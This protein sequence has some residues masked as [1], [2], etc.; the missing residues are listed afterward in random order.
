VIAT[1]YSGNMD[2]MSAQEA[3]PVDFCLREV[4]PGAYPHWQNQRWAEPHIAQ[5]ARFMRRL[6]DDPAAARALGAAGMARIQR[7]YAPSACASA[8]IDRLQ[9]VAAA[10]PAVACASGTPQP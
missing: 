2:F 4:A 3:C 1:G 8:V 6:A 7:Q 10:R 9:A 5:A